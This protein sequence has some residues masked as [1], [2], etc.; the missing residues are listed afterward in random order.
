M[1]KVLFLF[2]CLLLTVTT[3]NASSIDEID[4]DIFLDE[5]G[6]ATITEKWSARP[7]QGTEAWHPYYNLGD[8]TI[9]VISA[10][11]DGKDY[12]VESYWNENSSLSD[13]AYKAG[14]YKPTHKETDIVFG[15][16]EYGYHNY[17]VV[18]TISNFV[19][20]A[21]DADII[22]WQLFPY[23]FSTEPGN[24]KIRVHGPMEYQDTID[25]WGYG[26]YGA[27]CYVKDGSIYITSDGRI[28]SSEYLTLLAKFPKGTFN[29]S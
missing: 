7:T 3:V 5:N 14:I 15:I 23:E 28:G 4:M 17:E 20:S 19:K 21:T 8:S 2:I 13:K 24:V 26:T 1:K 27:P 11:M 25:V 18:Y 10:S 29:T 22:Y 16:T 6:N 12:T 9:E